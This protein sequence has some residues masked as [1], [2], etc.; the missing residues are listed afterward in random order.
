MATWTASGAWPASHSASS[1]TSRRNAPAA[2]SRAASPGSMSAAVAWQGFTPS[3]YWRTRPDRVA[4]RSRREVHQFDP[5]AVGIGAVHEVEAGAREIEGGA[6][7]ADHRSPHG[8]DGRH[9]AV[10]VVHPQRE[11]GEAQLIHRAAHR[12][13]GRA[14]RL[15][16]EQFDGAPVAPE[17]PRLQAHLLHLHE[18]SEF[19]ADLVRPDLLEPEPLAVEAQGPLEIRDADTQMRKGQRHEGLSTR[20]G[21][22]ARTNSPT[23]RKARRL[24]SAQGMRMGNTWN[25]PG[26]SMAR[27]STT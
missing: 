13:A 15:E 8:L 21:R 7:A 10:N 6:G 23:A 16:S 11:V 26:S 20:G 3:P 25:I 5:H 9:R 14:R 24:P 12:V 17:H 22:W 1:R 19:R 2:I 18:G 4:P 27:V